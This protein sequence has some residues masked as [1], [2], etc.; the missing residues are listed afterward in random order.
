M[1]LRRRLSQN[2]T[3][4]RLRA[5]FGAPSAFSGDV[6]PAR[7]LIPSGH[8]SSAS[9]TG[10][11]RVGAPGWL[12]QSGRFEAGN[13][14]S[15]IRDNHFEIDSISISQRGRDIGSGSAAVG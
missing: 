7:P 5:P 8:D 1:R 10:V 3:N 9:R 11:R 12:D 4:D 15:D 13:D 2:R 6:D 14:F